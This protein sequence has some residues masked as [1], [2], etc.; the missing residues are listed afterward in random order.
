MLFCIFLQRQKHLDTHWIFHLG[1]F[2]YYTTTRIVYG[3]NFTIEIKYIDQ[4]CIVFFE[5]WLCVSWEPVSRYVMHPPIGR[6][7][8]FPVIIGAVPIIRCPRGN[9]AEMVAVVRNPLLCF[10]MFL[11]FFLNRPRHLCLLLLSK[12]GFTNSEIEYYRMAVVKWPPQPLHNLFV[13]VHLYILY[14]SLCAQH[15]NWYSRLIQF[16]WWYRI[17][18][19]SVCGTQ[20]NLGSLSL[21]CWTFRWLVSAKECLTVIWDKINTCRSGYWI[22]LFYTYC[23]TRF[24]WKY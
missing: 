19:C 21:E 2:T 15:A 4:A 13:A 1:L 7:V 22:N 18:L 9:A 16:H 20:S 12:E 14:S 3:R 17:L 10:L 24:Y 23:T 8:S 6:T 5:M 11:N